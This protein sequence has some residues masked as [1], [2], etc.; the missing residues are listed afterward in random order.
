MATSGV[1]EPWYTVG[2]VT[3]RLLGP[4]GYEITL[5]S[6]SG[7]I[8]NPRR[9]AW[10]NTALPLSYDPVDACRRTEVPL[11]AAAEAYYREKGYLS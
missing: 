2:E 8:K 1:G 6:Q 10:R 11:H 7:S 3:Q 5:E 4:Q 9:L